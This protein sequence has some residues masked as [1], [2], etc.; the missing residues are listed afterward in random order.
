MEIPPEERF[1]IAVPALME[2]IGRI[3]KAL[4]KE[5]DVWLILFEKE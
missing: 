3:A 4:M 1:C 5:Y 2:Y